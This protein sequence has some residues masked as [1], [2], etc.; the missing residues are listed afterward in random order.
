MQAALVQD[1]INSYKLLLD[2]KFLVVQCEE[3]TEDELK[4]FHSSAY[5]DFL[6]TLNNR[7]VEDIDEFEDELSEFGLAYDCPVLNENYYL[8]RC[9]AGGSI[10]AAKL[11]AASKCQVAMNWFGGWH[12]AQR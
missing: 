1:L 5:I 10:S 7:D 2:D 8:V 6:K 9:L 11:L 4:S 12:H 3:A